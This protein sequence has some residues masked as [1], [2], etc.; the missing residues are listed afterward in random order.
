MV[1]L[2]VLI[3]VSRIFQDTGGAWDHLAS[4]VLPTY[5]VNTVL[6]IVGVSVLAGSMG[7]TTAWLVT[8]HRFPGSR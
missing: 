6:L 7:V 1:A 3:V 2:P 4:T 8:M 5:I